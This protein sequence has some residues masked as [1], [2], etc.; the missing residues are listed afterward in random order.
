MYDSGQIEPAISPQH[1]KLHANTPRL[2]NAVCFS[3]QL[4]QP[5]GASMVALVSVVSG[6]HTLEQDSFV[7]KLCNPTELSPRPVL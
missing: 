3:Q 2:N 5:V 7:Q 4:F 1:P 6:S